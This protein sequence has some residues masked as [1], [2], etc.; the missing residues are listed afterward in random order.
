MIRILRGAGKCVRQ[1]DAAVKNIDGSMMMQYEDD[2][3]EK[4][5]VESWEFYHL[6]AL[7][8]EEATTNG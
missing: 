6:N 4:G 7:I 5:L 3:F 2:S 8:W 1:E